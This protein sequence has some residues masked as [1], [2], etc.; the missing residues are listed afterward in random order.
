MDGVDEGRSYAGWRV[1]GAAF[2]VAM[3]GWGFAFYGL[4]VYIAALHAR[5]GWAIAPLA[6][7]VTGFYLLGAVLI[8]RVAAAI[9]RFGP[10]S[11]VGAGVLCMC[12]ALGGIA[13]SSSPWH[14]VLALVPLALAWSAMSSAAITILVAPWFVRRQGLALGLALTGASVGGV[15]VVPALVLAIDRYGLARSL[16]LAAVAM[17]AVLAP[18]LLAMPILPATAPARRVAGRSPRRSRAGCSPRWV[19]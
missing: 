9:E 11:V 2:L 17:L 13:S 12:G 3:F 1:V 19:S 7:A 8:T 16:P 18:A 15:L 14:F 10:R 4:G 5:H 6:G